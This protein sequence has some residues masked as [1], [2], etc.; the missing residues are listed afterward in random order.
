MMRRPPRSTLFPYTTL[1]RSVFADKQRRVGVVRTNL[2]EELVD[3]PH[4]GLEAEVPRV[5]QSADYAVQGGLE[6]RR[7]H[8]FAANVAYRQAQIPVVHLEVVD[9]VGALAAR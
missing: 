7:R 2:G 9:V 3:G 6:Q 8:S 1:F 5:A 4:Q